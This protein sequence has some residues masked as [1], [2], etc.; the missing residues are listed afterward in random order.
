VAAALAAA[1]RVLAERGPAA[2]F[3]LVDGWGP[4]LRT[5]VRPFVTQ[6]CGARA[7]VGTAETVVRLLTT[8]LDGGRVMAAAQ[9]ALAGEFLGLTGVTGAPVVLSLKGVDRVV[10]FD[11]TPAERALV[12][13]GCWK[14]A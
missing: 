13:A 12:T 1:G 4:A 14:P 10:D 11:L 6:M 8:L 9:I 7:P 3:A 2:A 5:V